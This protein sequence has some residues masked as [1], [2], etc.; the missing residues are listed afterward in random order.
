MNNYKFTSDEVSLET[1]LEHHEL[2][3]KIELQKEAQFAAE[4]K[5]RPIKTSS[6]KFNPFAAND[7]LEDTY[8]KGSIESTSEIKMA[9]EAISEETAETALRVK[10]VGNIF[11]KI[12]PVTKLFTKM[13]RKKLASAAGF[14][15]LTYLALS[16]NDTASGIRN[17]ISTATNFSP[18]ARDQYITSSFLGVKDE[19]DLIGRLY[20]PQ[21]SDARRYKTDIEKRKQGSITDLGNFVHKQ[22]ENEFLSNGMA[23]SAERY[24]ED[25]RN[26]VFG[27]ID[28]ML[29]SGIPMEVKSIGRSELEKMTAP[30]PEHVS[31]ANFYALASD[32]PISYLYYVAKEDLSVRKMFQVSADLGR[33]HQDIDDVRT[34]QDKTS[35][36]APKD[37]NYSNYRP[38]NSWF[39][40]GIN[41]NIPYAKH[42]EFRSQRARISNIAAAQYMPQQVNYEHP[43]ASRAGI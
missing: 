14:G 2:I 42:S 22:I 13:T 40:G 34:V 32:S 41:Y 35:K 7:L 33:Y 25:P 19:Q 39:G 28:I 18:A 27:Y 17:A 26:K 12:R 24:V 10:N 4:A 8:I 15:L 1:I 43:N 29:S 21:W 6:K 36:L 23:S 37:K 3:K 9:V 31:Q 11:N 5:I 16:N 38:I 20:D 30:K